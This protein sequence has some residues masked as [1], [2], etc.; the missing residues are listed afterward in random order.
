MGLCFTFI[1]SY[2]FNGRGSLY[3]FVSID[4]ICLGFSFIDGI[5]VNRW[6]FDSGDDS[7][8]DSGGDSGDDSA[9][10]GDSGDDSGDDDGGDSGGDGEDSGNEWW[11]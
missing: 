4:P 7:G 10:G 2:H 11:R 5:S 9:D 8:D 1:W 3:V 6:T